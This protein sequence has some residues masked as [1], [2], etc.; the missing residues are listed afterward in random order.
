MTNFWD[1]SSWG[2]F[3]LVA[4][5]LASLLAANMLKRSIPLLE[6]SL[7]PTSVLGGGIR[8]RLGRAV[9]S[10]AQELIGKHIFTIHN[11]KSNNNFTEKTA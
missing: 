7:I 3:N 9:A 1:F 10:E 5:L 8:Y 4:V 11:L 6:K 2:F